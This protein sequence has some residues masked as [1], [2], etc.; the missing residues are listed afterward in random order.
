M[1]GRGTSL[2]S[3]SIAPLLRRVARSRRASSW[4]DATRRGAILGSVCA[5]HIIVLALVLHPSW[6]QIEPVSR[7]REAEVL[8]L[9][10]DSVPIVPQTLSVRALARMPAKVQSV[11]SAIAPPKTSTV[12]VTH[13]TD[14]TPAT[15]A[16]RVVAVVPPIASDLHRGYGPSDF[17]S[18]LQ[19]AQ[20]T[21]TDHMPG[22]ASPLI[23]GIQLQARSSIKG[24]TLAVVEYIRCTDKQL[25]MENGRDQFSTPQ[26]MDR[27]LQLDGCG[28]HLE[29]PDA[30]AAADE[31]AHRVMFGH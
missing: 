3:G 28:P 16:D 19:N 11:R 24:A 8:R 6:R 27:A 15:T 13:L 20:R 25:E 14:S 7:Q 22:G 26:L 9:N 2:H 10:F 5:G 12:V 4:R 18:A 31:V 17:R 21:K 29:H 30:D 1:A 23:G